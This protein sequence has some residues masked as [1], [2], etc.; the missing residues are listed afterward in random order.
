MPR[1]RMI[2]PTIWEDPNFNKLSIGA[3]LLFIGIFSNADDE[4]YIR[5]DLASIKRGIFGFD[6]RIEKRLEQWI[7][8]L[9]T[10]KNIHFYDCETERYAHMLK[11]NKYQRQRDDRV[12]PTT[13]PKCTICLTSV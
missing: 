5:A 2:A 9:R 1:K 13:Y 12:V 7:A 6:K 8:E 3:R 10:F 11:W 4:G